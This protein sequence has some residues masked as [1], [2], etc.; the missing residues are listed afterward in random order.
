MRCALFVLFIALFSFTVIADTYTLEPVSA[1]MRAPG[2]IIINVMVNTTQPV[3]GLELTVKDTPEYAVFSH[4]ET[5]NRTTG[6]LA[7]SATQGADTSKLALILSGTGS[8]ITTGNGSILKIYY[9]VS[10]GTGSVNFQTSNFKVY[11]KNGA[12]ISGNSISGTTIT[13]E[14]S[15]SGS[16]G[17][18]GGGGG[19]G[20]GS[21]SS[22][23]GSSASTSANTNLPFSFPETKTAKEK[24]APTQ[25]PKVIEI[26]TAPAE[27]PAPQKLIVPNK[28]PWPWIIG[29][30]V[31]LAGSVLI[32]Y[33]YKTQLKI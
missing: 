2:T 12:V 20:S 18:S 25:P 19:G 32:V 9:S 26:S 10:S 15:S 31:F 17:S 1:T 22:S 5:T 33:L 4:V 7:T 27:A 14:S 21:S 13:L 16:S 11:N 29:V 23:S 28:Q 6:A 8:G 24:S 3:Y 30:L